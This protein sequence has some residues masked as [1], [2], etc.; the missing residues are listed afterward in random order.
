VKVNEARVRGGPL[1]RET[2]G[3][4]P[5]AGPAFDRSNRN[6]IKQELG[7]GVEGLGR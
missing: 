4:I 6:L 1:V 7:S 5:E 2:N 3:N